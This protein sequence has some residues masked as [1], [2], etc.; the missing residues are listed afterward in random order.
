MTVN[1]RILKWSK[2]LSQIF[3][4]LFSLLV[5]FVYK[6]NKY[7]NF[8]QSA[9][10][11][12]RLFIFLILPVCIWIFSRVKSGKYTDSDV[13]D[14]K[15]RKSLYLFISAALSFYILFNYIIN[16]SWDL[17]LLYLLILILLMQIS[18]LL[19]KSSMHTALNIFVAALFFSENFV[20]GIVWFLI[21]ILVGITRILLKRHTLQEVLSGG[22]IAVIVSAFY[23]YFN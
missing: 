17:V 11:F 22:I 15:Q 10:K 2:F 20:W 18:N 6:E 5:F 12:L 13:S 3:N 4:P 8:S 21:S 9:I 23:L 1:N 19:I 16:K 14:R 7:E